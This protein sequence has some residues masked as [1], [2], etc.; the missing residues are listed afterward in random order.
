[1]SPSGDVMT[2][3][4]RT[5][6]DFLLARIAEDEERAR[7]L[8]R[9][10]Q[11]TQLTLRDPKLLGLYIPGWHDWP[12][13]EVMAAHLLAECEAKRRIVEEH[14]FEHAGM[15]YQAYSCRTCVNPE[16]RDGYPDE[17]TAASWPCATLVLLAHPY[18]DHPDYRDEWLF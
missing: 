14:P 5:L 3:P 17:W 6:A 15:P 18:S 13:V 12:D 2:V 10:A 1:M 8:Q 9:R 4:T 11:D 16:E 7:S